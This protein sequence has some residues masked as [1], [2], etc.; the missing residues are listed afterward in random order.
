MIARRQTLAALVLAPV[1]G[2]ASLGQD[3]AEVEAGAGKIA[4]TIETDARTVVTAI[5]SAVGIG[6]QVLGTVLSATLAGAAISAAI[7]LATP[8]LSRV[9]AAIAANA[10]PVASDLAALQTASNSII[11]AASGSY[12]AVANAVAGVTKT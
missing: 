2:C 7:V 12:S 4:L 9:K 11:A 5:T 1:S 10:A 6:L 3:L 8:V